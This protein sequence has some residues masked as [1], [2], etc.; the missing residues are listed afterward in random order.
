[1]LTIES[2]QELLL[3]SLRAPFGEKQASV[4]ASLR[5]A[6]NGVHTHGP[7]LLLYTNRRRYWL[8]LDDFEHNMQE[9]SFRT[10]DRDQLRQA[11]EDE[12]LEKVLIFVDGRERGGMRKIHFEHVD[13]EGGRPSRIGS[14]I[15]LPIGR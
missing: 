11:T 3:S 9:L 10:P 2:A 13:L 7:W 6:S 8:P 4:A 5:S 1:M 14:Q 12:A 15:K